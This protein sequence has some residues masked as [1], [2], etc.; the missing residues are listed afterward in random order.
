MLFVSVGVGGTIGVVALPGLRL[1][2]SDVHHSGAL[3][4]DAGSVAEILLAAAI[5]VIASLFF[6]IEAYL[7]RVRATDKLPAHPAPSALPP[8][9]QP[10]PL[11]PTS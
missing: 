3:T 2:L 7:E 4:I 11:P 9:D 10:P 1:L 5:G 8:P 6:S